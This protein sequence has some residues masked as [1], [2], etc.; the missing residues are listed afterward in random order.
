MSAQL[1]LYAR[2]RAR[3]GLSKGVPVR[4]NGDTVETHGQPPLT[5]GGYPQWHYVGK[6]SDFDE[7]TSRIP[8]E[9]KT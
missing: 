2:V 1:E 5:C 4:C 8:G 7:A 3:L 6:I 9:G